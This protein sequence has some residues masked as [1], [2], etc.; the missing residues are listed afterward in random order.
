MI[1]LLD[2]SGPPAKVEKTGLSRS[3]ANF[4]DGYYG[5]GVPWPSPRFDF[6]MINFGQ[7]WKDYLTGLIWQST[8]S[9]TN[10]DWEDSISYC[11]NL[12]TGILGFTYTDWRLPNINEMLSLIDRGEINPALPDG[13]P[14]GSPPNFPYWTSTAY[15]VGSP[16]L[17][18]WIVEMANGTVRTEDKD[19]S[20]YAWCVRGP[21]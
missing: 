1:P 18:A 6:S 8:V 15:A 21:N 9:N 2:D 11:E 13:H 7:G 19:F 16:S 3:D 5:K 17:I 10:R 4:D 14:F 12:V 20:Y